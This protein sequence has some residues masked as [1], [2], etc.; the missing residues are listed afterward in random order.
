MEEKVKNKA[1][2]D[3]KEKVSPAL[4]SAVKKVKKAA[5]KVKKKTIITIAVILA[6]AIVGSVA[7]SLLTNNCYTPVKVMQK[8]SN[9]E[10]IS[11]DKMNLGAMNGLGNK[12][13][14]KIYKI[15]RN[16]DTFMETMDYFEE[17][18]LDSYADKQDEYGDDFKITYEEVGKSELSKSELRDYRSNLQDM[19]D[20]FEDA[21]DEAKDYDSDDWSD[22]ADELELTKAECREL[23]SLFGDLADSLGRLE[24]TKG[25]ELEYEQI[26]TGSEL[27]EPEVTDVTYIVLKVNGRWI[28][29]NSLMS[30]FDIF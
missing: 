6:L 4:G 7:F 23:I 27:D 16:S 2:S 1:V 26:I 28:A 29:Y 12:E 30:A 3:I 10:E 22:M 25:Y 14:K 9:T 24:V 11:F 15:L 19:V 13:W 5:S 8:L 20:F 17:L 18:F 21:A